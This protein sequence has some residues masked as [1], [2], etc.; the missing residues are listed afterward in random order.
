MKFR[1]FKVLLAGTAWRTF[2]TNDAGQMLLEAMSAGDEQ[3]RM[4]AGMS[5]V[6]AGD[7]SIGLIQSAIASNRASPAIIRLLADLGGSKARS[8]LNEVATGEPCDL[9][10]AAVQSLELLNRIDELPPEDS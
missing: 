10:N 4:M 3:E 6:K 5:L 8:I 1:P 7:R 2:G 9:K